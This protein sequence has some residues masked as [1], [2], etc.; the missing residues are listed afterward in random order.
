MIR[1]LTKWNPVEH[2]LFSQLTKHWAGKPLETYETVL[3]Y[4]RTTRTA[5]GLR[6]QARLTCKHYEKGQTVSDAQM[7]QINLRRHTTLPDWNYTISP[8][9][10]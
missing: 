7:S 4:I 1:P 6:V 2:R 9:K 10:M 5:T 3:N 8:R